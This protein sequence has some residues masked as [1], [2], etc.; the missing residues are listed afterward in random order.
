MKIEN[1]LT[2]FKYPQLTYTYHCRLTRPLPEGSAGRKSSEALLM[3][4]LLRVGLGPS[5]KT[6]PKWA[7]QLEQVTSVRTIPGFAINNSRLAPTVWH[8]VG[9][10]ALWI[11]GHGRHC[12]IKI[13]AMAQRRGSEVHM[14][15]ATKRG[16][17][18]Q[19]IE[20]TKTKR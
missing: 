3:Q 17:T 14:D 9:S 8:G 15:A 20:K 18:G 19:N 2:I 1:R 10:V 13:T 11:E 16:V 7:P 5:L 12:T 4:N 6:C